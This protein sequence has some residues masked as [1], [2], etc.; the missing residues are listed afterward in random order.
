M[1]AVQ[2]YR[3]DYGMKTKDPIGVVFEKRNTE[4]ATNYYDLLRLARR[5]FAVDTADAVH[6]AIDVGG[7]RRTL[8]P[9]PTGDYSAG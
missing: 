4:R 3:V 1:R 2:V 6:I 8:L 5:F 7:T 9:D